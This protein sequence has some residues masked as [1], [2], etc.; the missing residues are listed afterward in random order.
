MALVQQEVWYMYMA[1]WN[2]MKYSRM[3]HSWNTASR[4]HFH[5]R[6]VIYNIHEVYLHGV[7]LALSMHFHDSVTG[8]SFVIRER[9]QNDDPLVKFM[10]KICRLHHKDFKE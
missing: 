7:P 6:Y 4:Y 10:F 2:Q 9:G 5:D 1:G 8:I 3:P